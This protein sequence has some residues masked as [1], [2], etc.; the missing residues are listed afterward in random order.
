MRKKGDKYEK[1]PAPWTLTKEDKLKLCSY[2][3]SIRFPDGFTSNI[4]RCVDTVGCK[5]SG[6]KTHD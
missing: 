1:P 2:L 6:L 4:S 3:A 5:V